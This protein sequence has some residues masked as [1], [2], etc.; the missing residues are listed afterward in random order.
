MVDG[1]PSEPAAGDD[2]CGICFTRLHPS[3]NPRGRLNSCSHVF[4]AYC[5]KEWAKSTNVCP[6]CKARFTRIFTVDAAGA[7]ETTK[8]RRRNY[9]LWEEEEEEEGEGDESESNGN[10]SSASVTSWPVCDV[11]GQ[12]D[13]A[14]RMILCDRRQCS[15]T[16]HLDCVNLVERP[17]EYFCPQCTLIRAPAPAAVASSST[18]SAPFLPLTAVANEPPLPEAND[19]DSVTRVASHPASAPP[20]QTSAKKVYV[21]PPAWLQAAVERSPRL[22]A[23]TPQ[24]VPAETRTSKISCT[25]QTSDVSYEAGGDGRLSPPLPGEDD[26]LHRSAEAALQLF[27]QRQA[28]QEHHTRLRQQRQAGDPLY[29]PVLL[30]STEERHK[31]SRGSANLPWDRA[32]ILDVLNPESRRREEEALARRLALELLPIL[33]RNRLVQ[34]NQLSLGDNGNIV[35]VSLPSEAERAKR[36]HDLYTQAMTEG[37]RMARARIEAKLADARLRKERLLKVQAQ[38]ESAALAK[39]ARIVASRRAKLRLR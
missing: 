21:A 32:G 10:G 5:I 29:D 34:E 30:G 37:R 39:L 38:R 7:E 11:C 1:A 26:V 4:C 35:V 19:T 20:S 31:R 12:S 6:H 33:R 22:H 18:S 3:D 27:L 24:R 28:H 8:V 36:E 15:N 9:K 14:I 13:N 23:G 2:M 17:E 25:L 16:V